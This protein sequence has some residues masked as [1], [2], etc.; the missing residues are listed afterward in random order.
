M[1][2]LMTPA[3]VTRPWVLLEV[4]AAWEKE[5]RIVPVLLHVDVDL[6]PVMIRSKKAINL[7]DFD[8]YLAELRRRM[9]DDDPEEG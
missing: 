5:L 7:N 8:D 1:V 6:I 9:D 2:V 3:S 4:G